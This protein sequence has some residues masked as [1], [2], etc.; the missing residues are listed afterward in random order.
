MYDQ[1]AAS[2]APDVCEKHRKCADLVVSAALRARQERE[3][4]RKEAESNRIKYG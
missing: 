1:V 4:T 3:Q 2:H